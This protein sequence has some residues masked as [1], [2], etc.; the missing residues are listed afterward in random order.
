MVSG[1]NCIICLKHLRDLTGQQVNQMFSILQNKRSVL[2]KFDDRGYMEDDRF[3][4]KLSEAALYMKGLSPNNRLLFRLRATVEGKDTAESIGPFAG[5]RIHQPKSAESLHAV[6]TE[7]QKM[8][9]DKFKD[10]GV[11]EY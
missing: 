1:G 4:E 5:I 10:K 3:G 11:L 9:P 7:M 2:K 6:I 8:L